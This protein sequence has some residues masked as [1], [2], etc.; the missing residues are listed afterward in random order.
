VVL[1][2]LGYWVKETGLR[3]LAVAG[4]VGLN[5]KLNGRLLASGL[6]DQLF[7]HPLCADAGVPIGAA[8][9][10]E[11]ARQG[12]LE[13]RP[14]EHLFLG[15]SFDDDQI[16]QT[17]V[18][19]KLPFRHENAIEERAAELLAQ[20]KV[21]GWFQG[22]MEGGPRALGAR[23]ILADPRTPASRDRVNAVIKF[24][25]FWRPF[26]PSM[27]A[28]GARR[29][30]GLPAEVPF[31]ILA[32]P[33]TAAAGREIPAVVHVDGSTRPQVVDPRTNPAY[34]R[35]LTAFERRTGVPCLLNTS[36]NIKGEPIV[37][38]PHDALRTYAATGMDALA[39]GSFLLLKEER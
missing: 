25:E 14:L 31:M 32:L 5:V 6:L 29:F 8:L 4:G 7:V 39:L 17:L 16:R 23:S 33:A 27:T 15:P 34:H 38:T 9:A 3:R 24:R 37:C 22:R 10:H 19:C 35:L 11:Y 13:L 21:V 26:C 2:M 1:G 20:G 18:S 12:S 28:E 36:F 30:L